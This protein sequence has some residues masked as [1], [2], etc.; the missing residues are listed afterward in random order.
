M[1][2]AVSRDTLYTPEQWGAKCAEAA[3]YREALEKWKIVCDTIPPH[4][5]DLNFDTEQFKYQQLEDIAV[6]ATQLAL[7]KYPTKVL[8]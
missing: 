8:R 6:A 1:G 3:V 5:T 7:R 4:P 2:D